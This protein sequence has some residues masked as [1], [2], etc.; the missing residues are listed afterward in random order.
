MRRVTTPKTAR[1]R[2][3]ERGWV[4]RPVNPMPELI[5]R[6]AYAHQGNRQLAAHYRR[7]TRLAEAD[8]IP[9]TP[10]ED[11]ARVEAYRRQ[12]GQHD[13]ITL[14][15]RQSR[16]CWHKNNAALAR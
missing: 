11:A 3:A 15:P 5:L 14:T 4:F 8:I 12:N 7:E 10:M 9:G 13:L 16:R 6:A 2:A 1:D